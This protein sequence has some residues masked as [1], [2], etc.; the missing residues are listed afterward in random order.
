MFIVCFNFSLLKM[1]T[2]LIHCEC[3]VS[4]SIDKETS[5]DIR[6]IIQPPQDY[7]GKASDKRLGVVWVQFCSYST[8]VISLVSHPKFQDIHPIDNLLWSIVFFSL[9][10]RMSEVYTLS[11]PMHWYVCFAW[12]LF[13]QEIEN[14]W[15][16]NCFVFSFNRKMCYFIWFAS[17]KFTGRS[18]LVVTNE[19]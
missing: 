15:L 4:I 5:W 9:T 2:I 11:K 18:L 16:A 6:K 7:K 13:A 8:K 17:G 12:E 14:T 10:Q 3:S 19:I 1:T